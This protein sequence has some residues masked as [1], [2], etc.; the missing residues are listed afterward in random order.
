MQN[1]TFF[2]KLINQI[3]HNHL[4]LYEL[5]YQDLQWVSDKLNINVKNAHFSRNSKLHGKKSTHKT[6]SIEHFKL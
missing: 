6:L 1:N 4:Y 5:T 3:V 2:K